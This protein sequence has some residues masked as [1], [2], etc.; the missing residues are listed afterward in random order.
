M[1][2]YFIVFVINL[3]FFILLKNNYAQITSI[4]SGDWSSPST[5]AFGVV[6]DSISNIVIASGHT[7]TI[8]NANAACNNISFQD[9]LGFLAMGSASSVLSVFGDYTLFPS[10][11]YKSFT[12][13][14]DGAKII[15]KGDAVQTLSGWSTV[16]GST[17]FNEIIVD[18]TGGM[19]K[20]DRSNERFGIGVSLEIVRGIFLLDSLDDIESRLFNGTASSATI[21]V[22]EEGTFKMTGGLSHIRRASN[23][24]EETKKIGVMTVYG[25]VELSTTSSNLLNFTGINIESGGLLRILLGWSSARFNPGTI[26]VKNGGILEN[27]TTTNVWYANT[28]TTTTVNVNFGGTYNTKSS[29]TNLPPVFTNE[30]TFRYSRSAADGSQTILDRDYHRLEISFV[31]DGTGT[32]TWTLLGNRVVADSLEINNS[33]NFQIIAASP[34][35]LTVNG[36]LRLTSGVFKNSDPNAIL[37]LADETVISRATGQLTN[38]PTFL[39]N[40]NLR[41]TS[42]VV[43]V[44]TGP[45]FPT[46]NILNDLSIFSTG[47]VVTLDVN[48]TVKRTLTLS[49]GEFD[50]DGT[51]NDKILSIADST[52]IRRATGTLSAPPVFVNTV[53]VNYISTVSQVTTDNEIPLSNTALNDLTISGTEGVTLSRNISLNGTLLLTGSSLYTADN[54]LILIPNAQL[55]ESQGFLVLGK[56]L[57]ERTVAQSVNETF[58]G[59]GIEINASGVAPGFTSVLRSTGDAAANFGIK[60]DYDINPANNSGLNATIKI[61]YQETELDTI[62]EANLALF[63]SNDNGSTWVKKGG[64]V[65]IVNNNV[66]LAGVNSF[67]LWAL[68]DKDYP[69]SID[70]ESVQ[71]NYFLLKQNYPNPFNPSTV[72][73]Y[74][75]TE[76][77]FVTLKIYNVLGKEVE[78]LVNDFQN[79]GQYTVKFS[80]EQLGQ[81]TISSGIYFYRLEAGNFNSVKKMILIR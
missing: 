19:V 65:D 36:T 39:G 42:T 35:T 20:T 52:T 8:D 18:K 7:I 38:A 29:T 68:N 23:T 74:Q 24:G 12:A 41:Y 60:R 51:N 63:E 10:H 44:T 72:I 53:N 58:G 2:K 71:P 70:N 16:T 6:P 66:S 5:W 50:N 62:Q 40:I 78:A 81:N 67:A 17:S 3:L 26:T 48:A 59:I 27:L 49:T 31:G 30:G 54:T 37:Q 4:A 34:Q 55:D 11:S 64:T 43:S 73:Q 14:P 21:T 45:E 22:H 61:H 46:T 25:T 13:W 32:K 76:N 1:R 79:A 33:A 9:T 47:Q 28:T 80:T 56:V 77:S 57:A 75:L 69:T 15:F